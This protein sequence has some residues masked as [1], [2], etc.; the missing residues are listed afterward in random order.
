MDDS[1][2]VTGLLEEYSPV[3]PAVTYVG[4]IFAHQPTDSYPDFQA[5]SISSNKGIIAEAHLSHATVDV[6]SLLNSTAFPDITLLESQSDL[7]NPNLPVPSNNDFNLKLLDPPLDLLDFDSVFSGNDY[8]MPFPLIAINITRA[9]FGFIL[10]F[11]IMAVC[12]VLIAYRMS[13]S[14][15]RKPQNKMLRTIILV[16]AAFFVCWAPYHI[17]GILSLVATPGTELKESLILWDHLSVALA[18][19]NSCINPLLYVFVGRDFRAKARQSLQGVLEGVFTEEPTCSSPYSL[20]R[21]KTSKDMDVS[22][23]V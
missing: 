20:D 3:V 22:T 10:P 4:T 13:A 5:N 17:V 16:I 23:T 2:P 9:V 19:A 11:G 15:Y 18:Y 12:Y 7:P 21:S 8:A 6:N 1:D 14:N